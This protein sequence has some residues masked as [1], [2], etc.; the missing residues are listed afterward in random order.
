MIFSIIFVFKHL[1]KKFVFISIKQKAFSMM[2]NKISE[3]GLIFSP[4]DF[5]VSNG[6]KILTGAGSTA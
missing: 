2:R 1:N 5:S 6:R 4:L 3:G